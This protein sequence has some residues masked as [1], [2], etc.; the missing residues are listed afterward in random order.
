MVA[1]GTLAET[2]TALLLGV[3]QWVRSRREPVNRAGLRWFILV[4]LAGCSLFVFLVVAPPLLGLA[5]TGLVSQGYAFAFFNVMHVGLAL[6]LLR[7]KVLNLDRWSYYIWLWLSG[8]LLL[9]A[10][11][12]VILR[13]LQTQP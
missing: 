1:M 9:L 3:V 12:V 11:D 7:Y 6:G 10:L 2:T 4:S 5:Q 13:L 8:M